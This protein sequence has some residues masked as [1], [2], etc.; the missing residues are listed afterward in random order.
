MCRDLLSVLQRAAVLKVCRNTGCA[1]SVTARGVGKG[2]SL[3]PPLDHVEHVAA[4]HR[5][6]GELVALF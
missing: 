2:G 5:I 3:G 1:K 6:A 4:D